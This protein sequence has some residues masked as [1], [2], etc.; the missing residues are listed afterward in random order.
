MQFSKVFHFIAPCVCV[1]GFLILPWNAQVGREGG[2][3][4]PSFPT[5]SIAGARFHHHFS[6]NF[7]KMVKIIG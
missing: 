4:K 6:R 2:T 5:F 1:S 7:L 3:F